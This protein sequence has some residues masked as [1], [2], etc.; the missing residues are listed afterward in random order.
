M[1]DISTDYMHIHIH[2]IHKK[3]EMC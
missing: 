2:Y 1:P 3:W